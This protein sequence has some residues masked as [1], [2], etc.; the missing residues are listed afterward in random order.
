MNDYGIQSVTGFAEPLS[1]WSHLIGAC[2]FAVLS[3]PLMWRALKGSSAPNSAGL[4]ARV[5]G[6][7]VF[8][9][10]VVTLLVISGVYHLL[11]FNTT[12][13]WVLLR[14]DYAAI[15]IL[16][17]GSFTPIFAI[18]L[19]G[20]WRIA[21]LATIWSVTIAG[22][23]FKTLYLSQLSP[24]L[25]A[26]IYLGIGSFGLIVA[27]VIWRRCGPSFVEPMLLSATAYVAG[28]AIQLACRP[29]LIPGIVGP[30]ELFHIAVLFG[31]ACHWRFVW[32]FADGSVAMAESPEVFVAE[33][34]T[35]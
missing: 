13:R 15:F 30:H 31:I 34:A 19:R 26:V 11:G 28:T 17:A 25:G 4:V 22:I 16:I 7:G 14:L 23:T 18:L 35:A 21:A 10:T 24:S 5:G 3:V 12:G 32:Q 1:S 20:I 2:V 33:S 8:C 29:E 9:L 6:V 27:V